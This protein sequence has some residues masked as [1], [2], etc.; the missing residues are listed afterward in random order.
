MYLIFTI[1]FLKVLCMK[2][3]VMKIENTMHR[4]ASIVLENQYKQG[5]TEYIE[6]LIYHLEKSNQEGKIIDY[7]I[8]NAEKMK[9][10]KNR[11]DAIKNLTKA[12]SIM[13]YSCDPVKNIKLIMDLAIYTN[14][15]VH[16]DL[17][18]KYYLSIEKYKENT[19]F[20]NI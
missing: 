14:K 10:L 19:N 20:T 4:L 1:N 13:D 12:V 6:E 3:S 15:K 5:G 8:E 9:L 7:C 16:I 17:A 11:S 2:K 18:V